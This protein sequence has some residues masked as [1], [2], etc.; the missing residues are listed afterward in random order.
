MVKYKEMEEGKKRAEGMKNRE[1]ETR[2]RKDL[3][4]K[5]RKGE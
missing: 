2:D 4:E 1:E 5:V 3:E